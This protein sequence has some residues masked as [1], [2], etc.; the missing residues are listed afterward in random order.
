MLLA[1][2]GSLTAA[3]AAWANSGL[4]TTSLHV[5]LMDA[6]PSLLYSNLRLPPISMP[7]IERVEISSTPIV[8]AIPA[9]RA[10]LNESSAIKESLVAPSGISAYKASTAVTVCPPSAFFSLLVDSSVISP[11]LASYSSDIL[12]Y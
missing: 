4:A 9:R 10:F 11:N 5:T 2:F 7:A 8:A 12:R 1:K 6:A 3:A